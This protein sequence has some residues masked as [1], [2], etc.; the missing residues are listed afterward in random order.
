[1]D[2]VRIGLTL[3]AALGMALLDMTVLVGAS[4]RIQTQKD[5]EFAFVG[6]RTWAWHPDGAGDVRMALTPD[7]DP[8]AVRV[9]V[10]PIIKDAVPRAFA[11]RGLTMI[12]AAESPDLHVA[13]YVLISTNMNRQVIGQNVTAETAWQVPLFAQSTQ[14]LRVIEQG[15][16]ILDVS[17]AATRALVWRGVAQANIDRARTPAERE[18][19]L[20]EAITAMIKKFPKV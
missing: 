11:T 18:T 1:M 2:R 4:V 13:Y 19:R 3:V 17:R 16:L 14:Q 15:S 12:G 10:D 20:R 5:D 9:R 7:D 8:E 6:M